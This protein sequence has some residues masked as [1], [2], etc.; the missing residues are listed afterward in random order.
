MSVLIFF[1]IFAMDMEIQSTKYKIKS[2]EQKK[3]V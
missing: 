3:E 2:Y 1:R